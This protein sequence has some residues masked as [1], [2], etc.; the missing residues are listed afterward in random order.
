MLV[1]GAMWGGGGGEGGQVTHQMKH[2]DG[3]Q[4]V[5]CKF[6]NFF[7]QNLVGFT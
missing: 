5:I 4:N 6:S 1:G 3:G 7:N 2:Q